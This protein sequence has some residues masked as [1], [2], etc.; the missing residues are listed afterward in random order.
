MSEKLV[1]T[2]SEIVS[3]ATEKIDLSHHLI[4]NHFA[5]DFFFPSKSVLELPSLQKY[6]LK[7]VYRAVIYSGKHVRLNVTGVL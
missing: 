3:W 6:A 5:P 4:F 7:S 2:K 1:L